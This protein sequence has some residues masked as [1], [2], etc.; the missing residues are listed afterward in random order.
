MN[1]H[2]TSKFGN[3]ICNMLSEKSLPLQSIG[4]SSSVTVPGQVQILKFLPRQD[5]FREV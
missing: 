2:G 1:L 4:D 5:T 3:F